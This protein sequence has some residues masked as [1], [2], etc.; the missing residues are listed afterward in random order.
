MATQYDPSVIQKFADRLYAQA[1]RIVYTYMFVGF[2]VGFVGGGVFGTSISGRDALITWG[3]VVGTIL[4]VPFTMAG[5]A[6]GDAL[7]LQAQT[8]LCQ[9]QIESNSRPRS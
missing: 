5:F 1:D 6:R 7:R 9:V 4:A 3:V 8:A 2:I